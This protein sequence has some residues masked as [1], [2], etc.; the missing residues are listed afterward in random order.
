MIYVTHDQV[1]AMTLADL[2]VVMN[3]G[4]INQ[5]AAPT[6]LYN[7][8]ANKFVASFIGSTPMNFL[9]ANIVSRNDETHVLKMSQTATLAVVPRHPLRGERPDSVEVGIRP[10]HIDLGS[11]E[12]ARG[13]AGARTVR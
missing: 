8:P 4:E 2:V 12:D 10:E 3:Q 7:A 11:P 13:L 1:E 9:N 5:V 6:E